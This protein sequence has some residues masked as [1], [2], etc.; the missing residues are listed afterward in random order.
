MNNA[1]CVNTP[2]QIWILYPTLGAECQGNQGSIWL[3]G[4]IA[5]ACQT[6]EGE[7]ALDMLGYWIQHA[8]N[9]GSLTMDRRVR[10]DPGTLRASSCN[11]G[12]P[13]F[14]RHVQHPGRRKE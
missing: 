4:P 8:A 10:F 1:P 11:A 7:L 9:E 12:H 3:G 5:R 14:A 6:R 13:G 2:P